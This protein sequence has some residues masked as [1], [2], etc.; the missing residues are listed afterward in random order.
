MTVRIKKTEDFGFDNYTWIGEKK[1]GEYHLH[2]NEMK[3]LNTIC[4]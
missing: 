1:E 3:R 2:F 4:N